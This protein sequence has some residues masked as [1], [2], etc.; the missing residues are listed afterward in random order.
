MILKAD[1]SFFLSISGIIAISFRKI[2]SNTFEVYTG[3]W[4][5]C[6]SWTLRNV[7]IKGISE[8]RFPVSNCSKTRGG[9]R[10]RLLL[11]LFLFSRLDTAPQTFYALQVKANTGNELRYVHLDIEVPGNA[12]DDCGVRPG[13]QLGNALLV[14]LHSVDV[15][16]CLSVC[17]FVCDRVSPSVY[18]STLLV[19]SPS[20]S[21]NRRKF[22]CIPFIDCYAP[23][24]DSESS[25][26]MINQVRCICNIS[27]WVT[28]NSK[29]SKQLETLFV[30]LHITCRIC[31]RNVTA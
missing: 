16:C 1:L 31:D 21:W 29:T 18:Y 28:A 25:R 6:N 11:C 20:T 4:S 22:H 3:G 15:L 13:S 7:L 19:L 26:V 23:A 12:D 14:L 10:N 8:R 27:H 30:C 9:E 5:I 17:L 24:P 2:F